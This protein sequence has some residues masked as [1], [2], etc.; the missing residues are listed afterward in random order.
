MV[1]TLAV[2]G[3]DHGGD[4]ALRRARPVPALWA[5]RAVSRHRGVLFAAILLLFGEVM[6]VAAIAVMFSPRSRRR[7]FG[8]RS[9]SAS[10]RRA[11]HARAAR[12]RQQARGPGQLGMLAGPGALFARS[13]TCSTSR[14]AWSTAK[15]VS[16]HGDYV[17]WGYVARRRVRAVYAGVRLGAGD[18]ALLAAGLRVKRACAWRRA[19]LLA[20][21]DRSSR[22]WSGRRA[23]SGRRRNRPRG[24]E[25]LAIHLG[26]AARSYAP[27]N[28]FSRRALRA[29]ARPLGRGPGELA[30]WQD[31]SARRSWPRGR[32]TRRDPGAA[33]A[34]PTCASPR[35]MADS[36]SCRA[37]PLPRR[38]RPGTRRGSR[39]T[40]RRRW[41]GAWWRSWAS[42]GLGRRRRSSSSCAAIDDH[43]RHPAPRSLVARSAV[44]I[45]FGLTLFFVGVGRA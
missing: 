32:S 9:P 6:V 34:R 5:W 22:A 7:F 35:K 45:V 40:T 8:R 14:A 10:D 16:V 31:E 41:A 15:Y 17:A 44:G 30:A 1:L 42:F 18:A 20:V 4:A 3:R 25:R 33:R 11:L 43:D 27:G 38:G 26:R 12:G 21:R 37:R 39:K 29:L 24:D 19:V 23:A 2:L 36:A 28:P 13:A